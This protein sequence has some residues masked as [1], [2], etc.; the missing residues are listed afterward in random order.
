MQEALPPE[1]RMR[2]EHFGSTAVPG[3]T[4]KPIID[5]LIGVSSIK[6]ARREA[7]PTLES[8][9]YSFWADNPDQNR[10]FFV[11]G[12]PPNGPRTHHIHVVESDSLLWERLLFQGYLRIHPE[13]A[14][15]YSELKDRLMAQFPEDREVYAEGKTGYVAE[16]MEKATS[17][18]GECK[19][20]GTE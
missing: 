4:A 11:K 12:L 18:F 20:S 19:P 9:G 2:I 5:I 15:R 16:V 1:L 6:A 14:Q 7:L 17:Y 3:L 13:E 8:M 10:L